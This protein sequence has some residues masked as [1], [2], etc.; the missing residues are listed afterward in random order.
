MQILRI[1]IY[2]CL[3]WLF[4]LPLLLPVYSEAQFYNL[5]Q[6]PASVSWRQ[7]KTE[8]FKIIYPGEFEKK[9]QQLANV[10]EYE[11]PLEKHTL[12]KP[13]KMM[14][15]LLHTSN[16]DPNALTAWAPKRIEMFTCPPQ[17]SYAQDWMQQLAIHECRH[18]IQLGM[19]NQG[20]TKALSYV[21]GE[22]AHVISFG[23]FIPDWFLEG[24]AVCT[25]TLLSNSG[26][27]RV[28]L[29][30]QGLRTQVL[31]KG[32]YSYDKAVFGSFKDY[33][34]NEYEIGYQIVADTRRL[35]GAHA[36][37][38]AMS[39]VACKPYTIR[40]FDRALKSL[41]GMT[42]T[43]LYEHTITDLDSIWKQQQS[44]LVLSP[45]APVPV[46][47]EKSFTQ[48][49]YP[50]Y[51]SDSLFI[52]E[53]TS[54]DD[55]S[56]FV[57]FDRKG[58]EKVQVTPGFFSSDVFSFSTGSGLNKPGS[59]T[60]DNI[61]VSKGMLVWSEREV[62]PRWQ[63][64]SYSVIK[65]YDFYT[66]ETH[67]ITNRSR[68]F[69]PALSPDASVIAAVRITRINISSVVLIHRLTGDIMKVLCSSPDE[70]YMSPTWSPDG[71]QLVF[72]VL[73]NRGKSL[74]ILNVDNGNSATITDPSFTEISNPVYAGNYLLF[75][76][77]FSGI[78]NICAVDTSTRKLFMVTSSA[79]GACNAEYNPMLGKIIYSEYTPNGYRPVEAVFNPSVWIPVDQVHDNSS[80]L[81][82]ELL[83]QE[84]GIVDSTAD[85]GVIYDSEPYK[86][87]AHLFNFH[88]WA[89]AFFDFNNSYV[90]SGISV[91]SQNE[92]STATTLAGYDWDIFEGV[93]RFKFNFEYSGL[94]P[95]FDAG[96][97]YGK[98]SSTETGIEGKEVRY[99]WHETTVTG[100]M[101]IPLR[102]LYGSYYCGIQPSVHTTWSN[103]TDNTSIDSSK[104]TG[105]IHTL[106]YRI[107]AYNL[108]KQASKDI[109]PRWGQTLDLN[110]RHSPF[111]SN[112]LGNIQAVE[113][114]LFFPGVV[115]HHGLR[116]YAGLQHRT[117]GD[118]TYSN[119]VNSPRGYNS[120]IYNWMCSAGVTYKFPFLYPDYS[121]G[122]IAYFQRVKAALFYDLTFGGDAGDFD[123]FESYGAELTTDMHLFR[124]IF[125]FD[126]GLRIGYMPQN[127]KMFVNFLFSVNFA[128]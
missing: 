112:N 127:S 87:A 93:G 18:A 114:N 123:R 16:V 43:D 20:F 3:Q 41:T 23:L 120:L 104:L 15:I 63:Q 68:L 125:P 67:Q 73:N 94:Y 82:K 77:S 51:I 85:K 59:F 26:R 6:D 110:L 78:E 2:S 97:T 105:T 17:N 117:E 28:P 113:T 103:I 95:V 115:K 107:Y 24:D 8:H 84:A 22:Q 45:K 111:G 55:I 5:G 100:G 47:A 79:Y 1:K 91:V 124:F 86:K 57:V 13:P 54:L 37:E 81:Y 53:K 71:K 46:R 30:E 32:S 7:I 126:T 35:F 39:N 118:Y 74:R 90:N 101:K 9:A 61:S 108:K 48:Y 10:L 106:D 11:Y 80:S 56:R 109:Y 42:K 98:R 49:K 69:A 122:E 19:M 4:L 14:P 89:P 121:A 36:W 70:L 66:R 40:P 44:A 64:R 38:M 65:L 76:G 58:N 60:V 27:G 21:L 34:P 99:T 12:G 102:F 52:A 72:T 25:E 119:L 33:V 83:S 31:T 128:F 75:T 96:M 50:Q 62:D 29:F 92:L 116:I 88:S